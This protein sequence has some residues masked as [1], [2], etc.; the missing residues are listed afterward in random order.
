MRL[1]DA[2][3][4]TVSPRTCLAYIEQ[5]PEGS[6]FVTAVRGGREHTGW[7]TAAYLLA[8]LIDSVNM[9]TWAVNAAN[10]KRKPSKPKPFERPGQR[11]RNMR[12][13]ES[14]IKT[15]PRAMPIPEHRLPKRARS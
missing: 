7:D 15:N 3:S 6:A 10:A 4:G 8:C 12:A 2:L 14:M 1:S 13:A 9:T 5:L 11:K